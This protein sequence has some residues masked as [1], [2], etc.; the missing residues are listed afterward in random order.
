MKGQI[1]FLVLVDK[2]NY[3]LYLFFF[4]LV[5]ISYNKQNVSYLVRPDH[6]AT[7]YFC[8]MYFCS[9]LNKLLVW[10]IFPFFPCLSGVYPFFKA[11]LYFSCY[12]RLERRGG[13]PRAEG[14]GSPVPTA[15]GG[16]SC[17]CLPK[18][19][20]MGPLWRCG[21][22][23]HTAPAAT[24]PVLQCVCRWKLTCAWYPSCGLHRCYLASCIGSE[25]S[26]PFLQARKKTR[27]AWI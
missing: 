19:V 3:L 15:L 11:P 14:Q 18:A 7:V 27:T 4:N 21:C 9:M 1:L 20:G 10:R 25:I 24:T 8:S 17:C 16:L 13:R 22:S 2:I 5:F 23:Q 6:C 26:N 12:R